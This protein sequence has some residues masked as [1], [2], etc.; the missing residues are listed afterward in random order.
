MLS[1]GYDKGG[2]LIVY[3]GE[4]NIGKSIYLANDAANFVK[5]GTNTVVVT[6][7]MAAHKFV[8]RIGANLLS[9][10]I[11]QYAEKAKNKE[12]IKR[13]LET[14]GDGFSPPGSLFVKQLS[15]IH[16]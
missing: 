14:V 3:A 4:Q 15:L 11:N 12:H 2:N 13:R 6:A 16:I 1:G 7:E 10:N 8:K 9:V 5:M